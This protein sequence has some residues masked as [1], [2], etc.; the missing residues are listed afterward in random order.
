M[1]PYAQAEKLRDVLREGGADVTWVPFRGGHEIPE[2]VVDALGK[3]MHT[4][5]GG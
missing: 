3:W 4:A 1:L 5:L 2:P